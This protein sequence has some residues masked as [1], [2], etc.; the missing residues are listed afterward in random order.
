MSF[1]LV[2]S[3]LLAFSAARAH[4]GHDHGGHGD[5]KKAAPAAE[6]VAPRFEARTDV[7]ELV[8]V[9]A[10]DTLFVY[11]DRFDSNAPVDK[12]EIEI[13]SGAFKA[14]AEAL[15]GS[16][17]TYRFKAGPLAQAG[18]HALTFSIT[19]GEESDLLTATFEH[20]AAKAAAKSAAKAGDHDHVEP[21][22]WAAGSAVLAVLAGAVTMLT[23]RR[24]KK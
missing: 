24:R 21:W 20:V 19:A 23:R 7:F 12:A 3:M 6:T 22:Q 5:E 18:K 16:T 17:G 11:L 8:G 15:A 2:L 10:G 14:K 13:E 1:L 9:L 4:E